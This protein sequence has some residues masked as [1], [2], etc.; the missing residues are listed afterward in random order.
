MRALILV[1]LFSSTIFAREIV[2]EDNRLKYNISVDEQ[3]IRYKD[4]LTEL[5]LK[6]QECNAHI[7]KRTKMKFEKFLSKPFLEDSR[8]EFLKVKV[9][10]KQGYEPRYGDRA[11]FLVRIP[12]EIKKLKIEESFN[13][14][15]T[16]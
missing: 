11:I 4:E 12:D 13:C 3:S 5:T 1:L 6:K 14:K 16:N 10:G 15:K 2:V 7:I 8:P 9:D